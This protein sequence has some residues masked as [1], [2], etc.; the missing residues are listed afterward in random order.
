[1]RGKDAPNVEE[2]KKLK[3][4]L[5]Q[6]EETIAK[7]IKL[8]IKRDLNYKI[9]IAEVEK[10]GISTT[11]AAIENEL[12][13]LAKEFKD[14]REAANLWAVPKKDIKYDVRDETILR[15]RYV[16]GEGAEPELF[17]QSK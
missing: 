17:Y 11:G 6:L 12:E 9:A 15:T 7:E 14:Y 4:E 10:A 3:A 5:K 13:P 16:D 8:Q 2:K 1:L